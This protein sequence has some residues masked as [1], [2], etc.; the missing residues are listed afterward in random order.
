MVAVC[1]DRT[2]DLLAT[3]IAAWRCGAAYLPLDPSYPA[4]RI[5]YIL[6]DA[7]VSLMVADPLGREAVGA[8]DD[9]PLVMLAECTA[10][11]AALPDRVEPEDLAYILYTSG[12]TGRPKG[13]PIPHRALAN[14]LASMGRAP[15]FSAD[16]RLLAL[17]TVA[18]DIAAL[19]LFAP[20]VAGGQ[21]VLAHSGAGLDGKGLAA[22]ID[23]H[24]IT[25]MQA[26]PAG[27]RVL[28]DSGWSGRAGLRMLSGGEALDSA[29]AAT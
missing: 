27:W 10:A 18:F 8:L 17:T 3:L 19:E 9:L 21:I 6:A 14:F 24:D 26:T 11:P 12:S 22:M 28:R 5:A 2:P 20:L 7:N 1:Q 25:V 29:L 23:D 15:G 4:E 16:D 13:V